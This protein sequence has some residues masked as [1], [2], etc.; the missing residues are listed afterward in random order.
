[1]FYQMLQL[2]HHDVGDV[3]HLGTGTLILPPPLVFIHFCHFLY[4]FSQLKS[5]LLKFIFVNNKSVPELINFSKNFFE[6]DVE[7]RSISV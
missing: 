6:Q 7:R 1:M 2:L 5:C 4:N 3:L